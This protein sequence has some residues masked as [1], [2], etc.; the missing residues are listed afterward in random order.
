MQ[1]DLAINCYVSVEATLL[2]LA[3]HICA[4]AACGGGGGGGKIVVSVLGIGLLILTFETD[5]KH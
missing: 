2:Y 1:V 4:A 5:S 3:F